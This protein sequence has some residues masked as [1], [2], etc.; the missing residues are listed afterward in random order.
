MEYSGQYNEKSKEQQGDKKERQKK[1]CAY[2]NND[3]GNH[4]N[5]PQGM[6]GRGARNDSVTGWGMTVIRGTE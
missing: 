4:R 5:G 2:A 1:N 6:R 3:G